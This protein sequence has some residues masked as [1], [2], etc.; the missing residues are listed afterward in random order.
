MAESENQV[1]YRGVTVWVEKSQKK[2]YEIASI[3]KSGDTTR[4]GLDIFPGLCGSSK[5]YTCISSVRVVPV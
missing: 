4:V 1:Q 5:A 2:R 3:E